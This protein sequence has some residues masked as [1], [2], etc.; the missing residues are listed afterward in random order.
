MGEEDN[1]SYKIMKEIT[2]LVDCTMCDTEFDSA[3]ACGFCPC[4]GEDYD[5]LVGEDWN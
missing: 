3:E 4:W 2:M 5:S 1:L